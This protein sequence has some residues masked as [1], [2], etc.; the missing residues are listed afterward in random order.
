M[1][2]TKFPAGFADRRGRGRRLTPAH[3]KIYVAADFIIRGAGADDHIEG[4]MEPMIISK[5]RWSPRHRAFISADEKF[6]T[7]EFGRLKTFGKNRV[8]CMGSMSPDSKVVERA[9]AFGK[10]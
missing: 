8:R 7:D 2:P 3:R 4:A 10:F 6:L 1:G 9:I 5:V